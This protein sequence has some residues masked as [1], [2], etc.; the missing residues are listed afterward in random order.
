[1]K[2]KIINNVE[3]QT[4]PECEEMIEIDKTILDQIGIT[5]QFDVCAKTVIDYINPNVILQEK[6]ILK[7]Q[8]YKLSEDIIQAIV[9]EVVPNIE[10][11]KQ[12]FV[13]LHNKLRVLEGKAERELINVN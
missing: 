10:E 4:F 5:K 8:L 6:N 2:V 7:K 11:K 12:K 3:Y 13:K 1:M 9:G